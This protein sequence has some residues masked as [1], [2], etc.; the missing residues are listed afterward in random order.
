MILGGPLKGLAFAQ[1]SPCV[2][3]G[4]P[5]WSTFRLLRA[6]PLGQLSIHSTWYSLWQHLPRGASSCGHLT[7][8][9]TE[10]A[11]LKGQGEV[12]PVGQ[13]PDLRSVP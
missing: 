2:L 12:T 3:A 1:V 5:G 13:C 8:L 11:G 7:G 9:P 10:A 6:D 4:M